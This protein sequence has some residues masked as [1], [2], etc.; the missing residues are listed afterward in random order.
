MPSALYGLG[1]L[2]LMLGAD[3]GMFRVNYLGLA[4]NKPPDEVHFL[5]IHVIKIL[6]AEEALFSHWVISI[7]EIK[8]K[9]KI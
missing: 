8:A 3:S 7:L 1:K 9:V 5:V 6:R 4:R 2:S